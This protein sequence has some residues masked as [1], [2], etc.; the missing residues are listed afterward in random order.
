M[1]ILHGNFCTSSKLI[2]D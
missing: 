2:G 1:L